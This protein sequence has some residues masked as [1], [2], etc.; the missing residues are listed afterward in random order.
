VEVSLRTVPKIMYEKHHY[1]VPKNTKDN[2]RRK[3]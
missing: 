1:I 2:Q 3:L